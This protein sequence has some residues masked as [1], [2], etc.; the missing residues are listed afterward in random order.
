RPARKST[1][2]SASAASASASASGLLNRS[3]GSP[4]A[5][6]VLDRACADDA[7]AG[8]AREVRAA[9]EHALVARL[10]RAFRTGRRMRDGAVAEIGPRESRPGRQPRPQALALALQDY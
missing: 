2:S 9:I 10:P 8:V 3:H 1:W 4:R 7:S 5:A 6:P